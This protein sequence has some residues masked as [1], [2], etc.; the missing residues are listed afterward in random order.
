MDFWYLNHI[1]HNFLTIPLCLPCLLHMRGISPFPSSFDLF[2]FYF[3]I[4]F[5]P[6][7]WNVMPLICSSED[8]RLDSSSMLL[9]TWHHSPAVKCKVCFKP[10]APERYLY[11]VLSPPGS[12][13]LC[14]PGV[15]IEVLEHQVSLCLLKVS[16]Q[17]ETIRKY[18]RHNHFLWTRKRNFNLFCF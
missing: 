8:G 18:K 15:E 11:R 6:K 14:V 1:M 13:Q 17:R 2:S 4:S 9:Q 3:S 10:Q 5:L 16:S 12:F 7:Q